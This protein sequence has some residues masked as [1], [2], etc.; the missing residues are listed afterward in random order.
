[1]AL[2]FYSADDLDRFALWRDALQA[3]LPDLEIRAW[4]APGD[5]AE[6][7]YALLWQPPPGVLKGFP[8]L[9]AIFS[10]GAGVD[11]LLA[12][13]DLP[14][15]VPLCRMVD[16]SLTRGMVEYTV[17]HV[18]R[19]HREQ[20]RLEAMQRDGVWE[21]FASPLA[22]ERSVGVMGLGVIGGAAAEALAALGFRVKGWSRGPK[23]IEGVECFHGADGLKVFLAGT[24]ILVC[25][26]PLT[27]ETEGVLDAALFAQLPE[28]AGLINA[29]RGGQQNE[30]D[31]L[32][33]LDSGRLGHAT[34]DVFRTEPLPADHPFWR[35]PRVTVTPHNAAITAADS[36][37]RIV[38]ENIRRIEAGREP[39]NVVDRTA[40]Y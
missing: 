2:I 37:T 32:A 12:D 24:E 7:D 5:L 35:H 20:P 15:D 21:A 19:H 26:L 36:A 29:G 38:A 30:D 18:L 25:L 3:E 1:L 6:I 27:A 8:K 16:D 39:L 11:A 40:G 31:I 23:E 13:P 14:A 17:L 9:K 4:D 34:L 33:A 28:G 10:V 22:R